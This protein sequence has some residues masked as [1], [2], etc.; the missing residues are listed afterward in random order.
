MLLVK[1]LLLIV[2]GLLSNVNWT[3]I[4][5]VYRNVFSCMDKVITAFLT[6]SCTGVAKDPLPH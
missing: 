3:D 2:S 5:L 4:S 6:I 1:N